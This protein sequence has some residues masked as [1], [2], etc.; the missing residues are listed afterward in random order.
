MPIHL[1]WGDDSAARDRAVAALIEDAIDP[2]WS[3]INLS[4]L[5][6]SEG[7]QALQALEEARTPP[8]GAGMRVVLL[9]RSPFCNACP[10]ELAD[11]FESA[12]ELI[13]ESTQLVL[14]NPA[15]PDGRLRTTKALQKRVKQ[16]FACEQKFQLPAIWDGAGQRQLVERT[17]ADLNVNIESDAVSAL[18]DAL[19]L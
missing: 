4:R 18:V 5:D 10:S 9:Q 11:R 16:G 19:K 3:S 2:N 12:L 1:L 15:K 7:G 6:G 8:F 14:T 17:A 13:P